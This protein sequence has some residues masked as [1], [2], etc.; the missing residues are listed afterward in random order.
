MLNLLFSVLP[1]LVALFWSILLIVQANGNLSKK[2]LS[3]FLFFSAINYLTHATF[4]N[5]LYGLFGF[6]DNV[7][8]FTSLSVYPLYYYYV[9]LL[10]K[11]TTINWKWIWILIIPFLVSVFSFVIYFKMT[12][13]ELDV[14]IHNVMYHE[15]DKIVAEQYSSLIELQ[16]L[17][18]K[19][20]KILLFLEIVFSFYFGYKLIV[21]HNSKIR[22]FYSSVEGKDLASIKW[23]VQAFIFASIVSVVSNF[24]GKDYFAEH[25]SF[26]A[27]P[28]V[29][30]SMFLFFIGYVGFRQ[31]FTIV[32]FN[33][34]LVQ[35]LPLPD[36]NN[37]SSFCNEDIHSSLKSRL[38]C[39]F[40]QDMVFKNSELRITD[41]ASLLGSNR[42]YTSR[43]VNEDFD[44]NFCDFVNSYRVD[45]AKKMILEDK[46][47]KLS[48]N[49]IS[50]QSGFSSESSFYRAFKLKMG[51]SPVQYRKANS[52]QYG[53]TQ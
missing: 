46:D 5:H 32:D 29:T 20:F 53:L 34:D 31:D 9:R 47:N 49:D 24:I 40:E 8:V 19:V 23:V 41:V 13:S 3:F 38:L 1:M 27:I 10:T 21:E 2:F 15:N 6:L 28:S 50:V 4:F 26:L 7:W 16:I 12:S 42:T 17:R 18:M 48:I 43:I 22:S 44:T 36:K 14:F 11:D 39:L 45:Y 30:H 51:K 25:P 37:K 52:T 33:R 35:E